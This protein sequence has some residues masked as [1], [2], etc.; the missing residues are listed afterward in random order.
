MTADE[1][2]DW[3]FTFGHG[4]E[5]M[6][7]T[8]VNGL[9]VRIHGTFE[10]A[11]EEMF[12]RFGRQWSWQYGSLAEL[13]PNRYDMREIALCDI[14][15]VPEVSADSSARAIDSEEDGEG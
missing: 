4:H 13:D 14:T 9:Y 1:P 3:F 5:A 15:A 2:S 11:R 10:A 12:R 7:R 6:V 8:S